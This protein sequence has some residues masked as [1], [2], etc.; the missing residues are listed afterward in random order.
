MKTHLPS[1]NIFSRSRKLWFLFMSVI[2]FMF[3]SAQ[4]NGSWNSVMNTPWAGAWG[5]PGPGTTPAIVP[6]NDNNGVTNVIAC[7][8][9]AQG[10]W[11]VLPLTVQ[12]KWNGAQYNVEVLNAWNPWTDN[13]T[14]NIDS[15]AFNTSYFLKGETFDFYTVL[16]TG[17]YY[18]NL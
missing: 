15:E 2:S 12:Y 10:I 9:D 11:R 7:G 17:T 5:Y 18:F 14:R 8:Y 1:K 16:P 6:I 3:A 4:D 13:W